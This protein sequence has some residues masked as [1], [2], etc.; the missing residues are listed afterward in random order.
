MSEL[1]ENT[2]PSSI[3]LLLKG[4]TLEMEQMSQEWKVYNLFVSSPNIFQEIIDAI[5]SFAETLIKK[6]DLVGFYYNCY[7]IPPKVQAHVRFGF[8]KLRDEPTMREK[9]A[10]LEKQRKI[11][12]VELAQPDLRK[13][14][15][16]AIDKIKLTARKITEIVKADFKKPIT[17]QQA[18]YLIH[19]SM[20]PLFGYIAERE[21]YL[22]LTQA[23]EK[24][25]REH[26]L[27]PKEQWLSFLDV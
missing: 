21:I 18:Y 6:G 5:S 4:F 27:L 13:A 25:I 23:M 8:Y 24:A 7:N 17:I 9:I 16:V 14:D 20:N 3:S 12:K 26:N 22:S 2:K 19:L 15:E 10:E 11:T 1:L